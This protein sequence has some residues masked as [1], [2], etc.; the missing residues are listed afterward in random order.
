MRSWFT[1]PLVVAATTV[2]P[3]QP[4][5]PVVEVQLSSFAF[6]PETIRLRAGQPVTLRLANTSSGGHNFAAQ[7]FFAAAAIPAGQNVA[8][9]DGTI[10]V[11][12]GQTVA[13]RLTPAAGNYRLRCTHT[14]HSMFG[15]RGHIVVE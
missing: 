15:M 14:M 6:T 3:A 2:A 7:D 9:R 10:E 11:P 8:L 13:L 12:E 1:L 5:A 4:A